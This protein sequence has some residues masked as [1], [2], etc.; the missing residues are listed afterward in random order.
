MDVVVL[1]VTSAIGFVSGAATAWLVRPRHA[2]PN[3]LS[4]SLK[5]VATLHA[6][7]LGLSHTGFRVGTREA[8][9]LFVLE[10]VIEN[11]GPTDIPLLPDAA[12]PPDGTRPRIEF[13]D[14]LKIIADPALL[15][16][17]AAADIRVA[18]QRVGSR[19][20]LHVHVH[21]AKRRT[22]VS[23]QLVATDEPT[24]R[25]RLVKLERSHVQFFAGE[26]SNIDVRPEALL[27]PPPALLSI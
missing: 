12:A 6:G 20:L 22:P 2:R 4:M 23:F 21:R 19:Q 5:Q 26:L 13:I 24:D 3:E 15:T 10:L 16:H 14:G 27:A 9:V 1:L 17:T 8:Q 25:L 18:R 7:L 11:R